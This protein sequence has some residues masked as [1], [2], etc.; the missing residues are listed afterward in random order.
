[1]SGQGDPPAGRGG[2]D[3][4]AS[5]DPNA[6][7][8]SN[9]PV[10]AMAAAIR[11]QREAQEQA[12]RLVETQQAAMRA[13][14]LGG[15]SPS[16]YAAMS[17]MVLQQQQ[18]AAMQGAMAGTNPQAMAAMAAMATGKCGKNTKTCCARRPI[19]RPSN[20]TADAAAVQIPPTAAPRGWLCADTAASD[21]P[22]EAATGG[23]V[24]VGENQI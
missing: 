19:P 5:G 22:R 14:A 20:P 6:G 10:A 3:A 13:A 7:F 17:A 8:T 18:L 23:S 4:P 11:A 24:R 12:A 15:M 1:M 2:G 16:Q 21:G 9:D